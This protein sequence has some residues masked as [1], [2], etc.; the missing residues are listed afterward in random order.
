MAANPTSQPAPL[1]DLLYDVLDTL[2]A[3]ILIVALP[4]FR[5]LAINARACARLS[6]RLTPDLVGSRCGDV[7]PR[8]EEDGLAETWLAEAGL[9]REDGQRTVVPTELGEAA[10]RWQVSP[11]RGLDGH[12]ERLMIHRTEAVAD[13]ASRP[14][15]QFASSMRDIAQALIS[16]IDR[17]KLLDLILEQLG[18][19]V[20]YDSAAIMLRDKQGYFVAAGRGFVDGES[21]QR[22]RFAEDDPLFR[23]LATTPDAIILRDAQQERRLKAPQ[24]AIRGWMAVALQTQG[25]ILGMLTIDSYTPN[26]YTRADAA[27]AQAFAAYAAIAVR[28][29]ELY[30][31]ARERTQQLEQ[32]LADLRVAQQRLVQS[33]RLSAVG[34]LVAG[35]AHELNNPLT[36]VLGFA[37]IL[38]ATAPAELQLDVSPIVEGATR[39][40]R[41]VQ[42]LL[43]FAR[44]REANLEEVNLNQAVRHVLNL[45]S[46]LL[47]S[48]G[49]VVVERLATD[50]PTTMADMTAIQQVLLNLINNARQALASWPGDRRIGVRTYVLPAE[51]GGPQRVGFEVTDTGPGIQP[52]HMQVLFEPFFTTKP[53]GEGTGLGLSIC[54]GI[55][56]QYGGEI[57][58]ESEPGKGARFVVEL[59]VG[60]LTTLRMPAPAVAAQHAPAERR[61]LVIDDEPTVAAL[62]ERLLTGKGYRVETCLDGLAVPALL[63]HGNYDLIISDIKMPGF[64][65]AQVYAEVTRRSPEMRRRLLFISGDTLSLSTREFLSGSGC[66]FLEKPFEIDEFLALV[67]RLLAT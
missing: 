6:I 1:P 61:V 63:H 13:P 10:R 67:E 47:R 31:Q 2:P 66:P 53:V 25:E 33:E 37:S 5:V 12:V 19:V 17:D 46:Y 60:H 34:E 35:V 26:R 48:D 42:N 39:A 43:T 15:Q 23:E 14:E 64:G 40:R 11:L 51:A 7:I 38:Q 49:V 9:G 50:L 16:T 44:Q 52:E 20:A 32:A 4:D 41:I 21:V 8:F 58:V 57:R 59:P 30:R 65:G 45:Y 36:A 55:V 28:N 56:K 22:L 62:V 18:S 54:Y 29:A 27:R 3:A 24:G